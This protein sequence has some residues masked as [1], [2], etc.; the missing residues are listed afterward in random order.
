LNALAKTIV[1]FL[2]AKAGFRVHRSNLGVR[3]SSSS[4]PCWSTDVIYFGI[5]TGGELGA[6]AKQFLF[7]AIP[8]AL[9]IT[10]AEDPHDR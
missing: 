2:V 1:A 7:V 9:Y 8:S 4:S 5:Y 6:F 10:S 3:S